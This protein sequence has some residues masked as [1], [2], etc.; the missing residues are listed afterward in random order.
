MSAVACC[1][2]C[3]R[4]TSSDTGAT[5][6][7]P[8]V[9]SCV[10]R[11]CP[12][13]PIAASSMYATRKPVSPTVGHSFENDEVPDS[14][15]AYRATPRTTCTATVGTGRGCEI[16]RSAAPD[17]CWIP[18]PLSP[19]SPMPATRENGPPGMANRST[20]RTPRTVGVF[21]FGPSE[22]G[23]ATNLVL[24]DQHPVDVLHVV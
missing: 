15:P 18:A 1:I 23:L 12:T 3:P 14:V 22:H 13:V 17:D 11:Y 24:E 21:P 20:P 4:S 6:P 19:I 16:C 8:V 10:H 7:G 2:T 9:V 5:G